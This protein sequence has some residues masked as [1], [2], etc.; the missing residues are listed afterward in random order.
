M[1]AGQATEGGSGFR[2]V[3]VFCRRL[4]RQLSVAEHERCSYCTGDKTAI[5]TALHDVFCDF[6]PGEDP[7]SFGFPHDRGRYSD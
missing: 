1:N 7:V 3:K 6:K 5:Q 4:E 2:V